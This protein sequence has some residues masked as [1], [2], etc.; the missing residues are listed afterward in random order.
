MMADTGPTGGKD[1]SIETGSGY[2]VLARKYR[3][4]DFSDLVG[5]EPMVRTLRN[6][7]ATNRI[8]QAYIF[9][10]VRGVGKTTT[11]RIIARGLNF[12]K[13]DGTGAPTVD[14]TEKGI[15]CDAILE[16]RHVD[17]IEM[18]AAS[19][20]GIGDIREIIDQ[21]RYKPAYARYKVYIIDEVHMLSNA[22]FNGL[23]KTLEEPPPHVKFLFATTEI[24]KVPVTVLSRCQRFDLRRITAADMIAYL[25]M[26]ADKEHVSIDD[27]ALGLI[28]R[29]SEG[30]MRDALSLMDQAIAHGGGSIAAEQLRISLGLAD[31]ARV[32]D[33]FETIMK[34]EVAAALGEM[35]AQ[36]DSGADPNA[37]I[38]DL[39]EVVHMVTRLKVAPGDA[40]G[41]MSEAERTRGKAFAEA[42]SQKVLTRA[43]Q[44]LIKG[45]AEVQ[46]AARPITAAEMLIVRLCYAADLPTPDE[47][48]RR[49]R[50]G[51]GNGVA[52]GSAPSGGMP[53]KAPQAMTG[54]PPQA[55]APLPQTRGAL[56]LATSQAAPAAAPVA[57]PA[58]AAQPMMRIRR[59]EDIPAIAGEKRDIALKIAVERDIR[60][61]FFQ[62]GRIEINVAPGAADVATKLSRA[63]QE[64]TGQRWIVGLS[65]AEGEETL[66]DREQARKA[67][68]A[69]GVR[70][71]PAVR[72]VLEAFPGAEITR[73]QL[74][75][76][77]EQEKAGE[78]DDAPPAPDH[79]MPV[80][81]D[82]DE[83]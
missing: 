38:A 71:N 44:M 47:V 51:A 9:T 45:I 42:L 49:W 21:V 27:E 32:L 52:G 82:D 22:A 1:V 23:L 79:L 76:A 16:S 31:R 12:E 25:K 24:R 72:A 14:L 15:H 11:A 8:H 65:Q 30:S 28:A 34:G 66:Y 41:A 69:R 55:S 58:S 13:A 39:A 5:Q 78:D 70:A 17:I 81:D 77:E 10:G 53:P 63:L 75:R 61:V 4:S 46:G 68:E 60:L 50:D 54:A 74:T 18:D 67:D 37:I 7:F 35:R 43:W 62:E 36:Y 3:P 29:A 80:E 26:I 56:S 59:F 73:V 57:I 33:L 40:D 20:T 48:I 83:L 19:H 6:A 64:W 2:R